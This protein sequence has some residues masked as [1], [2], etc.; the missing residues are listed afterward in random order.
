MNKGQNTCRYWCLGRLL[1]LLTTQ[2]VELDYFTAQ[3]TE[4]PKTKNLF[5]NTTSSSALT[6]VE[7]WRKVEAASMLTVSSGSS[8]PLMVLISALNTP[9][10]S[11]WII[12]ISSPQQREN[13]P[14]SSN[15]GSGWSLA[16][17]MLCQTL[18]GVKPAVDLLLWKCDYLWPC[19]ICVVMWQRW[20]GLHS[21]R[22]HRCEGF[23]KPQEWNQ[24][25]L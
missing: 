14:C 25:W 5:Y 17:C 18:F 10:P 7:G 1:V 20:T 24:M 3:N 19:A 16:L 12:Q 8:C 13:L 9:G 4:L 21:Y 2:F 15:G 6:W 11:Q 22:V 23:T